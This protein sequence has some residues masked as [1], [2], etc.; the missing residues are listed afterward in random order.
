MQFE[1]TDQVAITFAEEFYAAT[2]DGYPVDAALSAGRKAIFAPGNDIEWGSPVLYLRAP[3]G[4]LFSVSRDERIDRNDV[5][6]R[7]ASSTG[8]TPGGSPTL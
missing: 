7:P 4:R 1:I 5:R 3:D 2:A 8:S 6:L